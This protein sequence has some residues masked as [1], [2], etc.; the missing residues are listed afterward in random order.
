M[1]NPW[2]RI[3]S[4]IFHLGEAIAGDAGGFVNLGVMALFWTKLLAALVIL[5]A[6]TSFGQRRE[7]TP[8]E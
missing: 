6:I 1:K 3:S 4:G 2:A 5:A 8:L 7:F